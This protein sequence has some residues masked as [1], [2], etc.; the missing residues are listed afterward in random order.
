MMV[1]WRVIRP[2]VVASLALAAFLVQAATAE[3][4][5]PGSDLWPVAGAP[6]AP[7]PGPDFLSSLAKDLRL[8]LLPSAGE[9]SLR[10]PLAPGEWTL[11]GLRPY[12]VLSPRVWR[13]AMDGLTGLA[14]PD[15]ESALDPSH[16]LGIGPGVTWRL[17][18]RLDLFG[19]YLF[20]ATPSTSVPT[21]SPLLQPDAESSGLKGGFSIRF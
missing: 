19:Q 13:P 5:L 17:S 7:S 20:R 6:A 15:R 14:V 3:E 8:S 11:S 18:D 2:L 1:R 12:A 10:M 16:G 4:T 9:L 21:A